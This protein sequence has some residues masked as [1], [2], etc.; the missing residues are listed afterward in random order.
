V[1]DSFRAATGEPPPPLPEKFFLS[2]GTTGRRKNL[3][4]LAPVI[5]AA[6]EHAWIVA[7]PVGDDE[8]RLRAACERSGVR[9]VRF[10]WLSDGQLGAVYRKA[11]ALLVPSLQEGYYY[12]AYEATVSGCPVVARDLPVFAASAAAHRWSLCPPDPGA[13]VQRLARPDQLPRPDPAGLATEVEVAQ[14]HLAVYHR[15][16]S[17]AD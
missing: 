1:D 7:G 9:L 17:G 8:A 10:D 11:A 13:W 12:P 5:A 14:A 6:Q 16:M 4:F 3:P 15:A 2:V